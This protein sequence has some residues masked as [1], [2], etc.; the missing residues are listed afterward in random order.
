MDKVEKQNSPSGNNTS[1]YLGHK[2]K[3]PDDDSSVKPCWQLL[4]VW[5]A[6]VIVLTPLV[7]LPI[8]LLWQERVRIIPLYSIC[9][10]LCAKVISM[11]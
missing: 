6:L 9:K 11:F 3:Q 7:L 1:L 8:P 4:K 5:K 10:H 2:T